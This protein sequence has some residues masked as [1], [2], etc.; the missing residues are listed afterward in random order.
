MTGARLNMH[1]VIGLDQNSR[2]GV[3]FSF[4]S[5]LLSPLL[6]LQAGSQFVIRLGLKGGWGLVPPLLLEEKV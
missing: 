4:C 2:E 3:F 5:S 1:V 6:S